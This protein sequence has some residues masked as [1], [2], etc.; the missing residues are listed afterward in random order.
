VK[1]TTGGGVILGMTCGGI[2]AEVVREALKKGDCSN[3][4]LGAY[5]RRVQE[6]LGF[7]IDVMLRIRKVLNTMTDKQIDRVISL[8]TRLGLEKTLRNLEDIDLQGRS[9]LHLLRRP[10]MLTALSYFFFLYLSANP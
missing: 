8:C 3:M 7:D 6:A 10:R 9:L 4:S 1:P 2:A 5:Q